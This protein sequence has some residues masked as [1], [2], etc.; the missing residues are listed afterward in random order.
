MKDEDAMAAKKEDNP[1]AKSDD[2]K[3]VTKELMIIPGVG[4][5]IADDLWYLDIRSV[6]ELK[7]RDPE[8]LYQ[9]L[10]DFQGMHVD[11]C[12]LYVFREA[13]YFAS[14]DEHDPELLKWWNWKD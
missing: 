12:M 7:D 3:T 5:T 13:V 14:N 2:Y 9:Q 10:C 8:E 1:N 11:R 4:K 6:S